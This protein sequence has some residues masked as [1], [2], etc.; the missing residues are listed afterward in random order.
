MGTVNYLQPAT[1]IALI[2]V[3]RVDREKSTARL[4]NGIA[5]AQFIGV[6]TT[7]L[8]TILNGNPGIKPPACSHETGIEL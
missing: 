1:G 6:E 5:F 8:A 7:I 4:E 2:A 3:Y